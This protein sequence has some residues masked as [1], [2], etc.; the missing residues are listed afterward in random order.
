MHE[1]A[2]LFCIDDMICAFC[3]NGFPFGTTGDIKY[4]KFPSGESSVCLKIYLY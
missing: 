1:P 4:R 3:G 2:V